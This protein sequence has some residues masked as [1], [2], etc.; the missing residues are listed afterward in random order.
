MKKIHVGLI[1]AGA[2]VLLGAYRLIDKRMQM[3]HIEV[4]DEYLVRLAEIIAD[5]PEMSDISDGLL[6]VH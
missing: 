3:K 2:A 5:K 6:Y 4:Y 1:A